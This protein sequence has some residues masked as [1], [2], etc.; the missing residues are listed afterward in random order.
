M[1]KDTNFS[2]ISPDSINSEFIAAIREEANTLVPLVNHPDQDSGYLIVSSVNEWMENA[3]RKPKPKM[4]F[5][6]FWHEGEM[7]ILFSD[8]NLGKSILAVQLAD[9]I[10]TGTPI[11]KFRLESPP[12][13]VIL[14]DFELSD[15][16][17][18]IRYSNEI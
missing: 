17:F 13:P 8:T 14:I 9:S 10:S 11:E 15:K 6:V 5:D 7:C 18:Q 3:Q 4:L 1:D 12:Q 2:G 16:Q